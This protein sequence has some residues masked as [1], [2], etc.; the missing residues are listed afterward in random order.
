[1]PGFA[2]MVWIGIAL[3]GCY[4]I[5]ITIVCQIGACVRNAKTSNTNLAIAQ[6]LAGQYTSASISYTVLTEAVTTEKLAGGVV[7]SLP[8]V[9]GMT[10]DAEV[11]L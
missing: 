10:G 4:A 3:G 11:Q 6:A 9:G 8:R 7:P 2:N 1:M 5:L